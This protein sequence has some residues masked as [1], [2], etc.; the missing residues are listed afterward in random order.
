LRAIAIL[1][2]IAVIFADVLRLA[3]RIYKVCRGFI[4]L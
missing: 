2:A 1:G 3:F 4:K